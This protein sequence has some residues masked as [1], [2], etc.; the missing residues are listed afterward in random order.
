MPTSS[1]GAASTMHGTIYDK[2]PCMWAYSM[3]T[4]CLINSASGAM[5]VVQELMRRCE[6]NLL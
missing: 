6:T 1:A 3:L 5:D 4:V 2:S